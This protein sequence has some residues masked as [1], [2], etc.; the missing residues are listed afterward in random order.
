LKRF[1][2]KKISKPP[3]PSKKPGNGPSPKPAPEAE[4]PENEALEAEIRGLSSLSPE[5]FSKKFEKMLVSPK[6]PSLFIRKLIL[7]YIAN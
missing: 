3:K 7:M 2:P 5:E 6:F 1:H 4:G